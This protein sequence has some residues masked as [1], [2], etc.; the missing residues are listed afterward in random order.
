MS[1]ILVVE[2]DR[3]LRKAI[4]EEL[5]EAGFQVHVAENSIEAFKV[6]ESNKVDLIYLDIMLPGEL[7][8]YGILRNLKAADSPHNKIPV[9]MLSNLGQLDEIDSAMQLGA[10]DFVVKSS[11]NLPRL[12]EITKSKLSV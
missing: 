12:V 5:E 9:V 6:L 3:L 4:Q 7:N 8:G 2:D 11:I 10:S 1:N